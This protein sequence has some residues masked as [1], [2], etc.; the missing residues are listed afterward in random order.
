MRH[1]TALVVLTLVFFITA[2]GFQPSCHA[3]DAQP[4]RLTCEYGTNP[5]GI[6]I[7]DPRLN[8]NIG[9]TRH[10]WI[11]SAY[12][13]MVASDSLKL[14]RNQA[15][16]WNTGKTRSQECLNIVY[17]GKPLVSLQKYW[18]KVR[19]WDGNGKGS[20]WSRLATWTMAMVDPRDWKGRWIASDLE[21][22]PLQKELKA[23]TDFGMESESEMW[24][25]N[26]QIRK[27]TGN[28]TSAPAVYMRREFRSDKR[29]SR[30]VANICGLGLSELFINGEKVGDNLL[31]PAPSDYQKRIFY[32]THDVTRLIRQG[33]NALGVMLGNGW[34][35]LVIPHALRY[36]AADYI[37]TPR[38]LFQL[39]VLYD[40][41]SRQTWCRTATGNSRPMGPSGSTTC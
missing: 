34:F 33:P 10:N 37:A 41:G 4:V 19:V 16:M 17:S 24:T 21:L 3:Q 36:Y 32:Q 40:D 25:L 1:M 13:V 8:W 28:I 2:I 9:T 18:W 11:Q 39:D 29:V 26:E 22:T 14:A 5:V 6:G 15:D 27:R 30:A 7:S 20:G 35:N 12:Q 31:D 23:L 38:L